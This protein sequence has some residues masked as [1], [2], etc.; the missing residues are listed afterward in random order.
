MT[1]DH[2]IGFQ[3]SLHSDSISHYEHLPD[4]NTPIFSYN[5]DLSKGSSTVQSC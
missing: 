3:F 5:P 4:S 2:P 1:L